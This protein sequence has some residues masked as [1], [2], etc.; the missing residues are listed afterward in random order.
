M[1][2][3]PTIKQRVECTSRFRLQEGWKQLK[4]NRNHSTQR[5]NEGRCSSSSSDI[6][7]SA[8]SNGFLKPR[9]GMKI[10]STSIGW[11]FYSKNCVREKLR[12]PQ[13][14][15]WARQHAR[16][17]QATYDMLFQWS[18]L[19]VLMFLGDALVFSKNVKETKNDIRVVFQEVQRANLKLKPMKCH[20]FQETWKK[21]WAQKPENDL[22]FAVTTD[23]SS[24][25]L[26]G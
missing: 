25:I 4:E 9:L 3:Y 15:I 7:S 21:N 19:L 14:S 17:L 24:K 8:P 16:K 6:G 11:E 23:V 22:D 1:K 20:F 2:H 5:S 10:L 26:L 18:P 12:V 13:T